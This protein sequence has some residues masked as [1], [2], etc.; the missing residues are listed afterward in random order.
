MAH[1]GV[2]MP[3]TVTGQAGRGRWS[4]PQPG[5]SG[6]GLRQSG[7]GSVGSRHLG[8]AVRRGEHTSA[9]GVTTAGLAAPVW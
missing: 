3:V 1:G 2:P 6:A 8:T 4:I 9:V 5:Q 7:A